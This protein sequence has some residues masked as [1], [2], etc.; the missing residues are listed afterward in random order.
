[1]FWLLGCTSII[2]M[3]MKLP[4]ALLKFVGMSTSTSCS[5]LI[6]KLTHPQP[7]SNISL[8]SIYSVLNQF[9]YICFFVQESPWAA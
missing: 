8:V 7:P 4:T 6:A 9:S 3:C 2:R 1:M 5:L